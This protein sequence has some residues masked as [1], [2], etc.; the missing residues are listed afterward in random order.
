MRPARL[1]LIS[2]LALPTVAFAQS[3]PSSVEE[4]A[5]IQY[6]IDKSKEDIAKQ[7]GNKPVD[8][9]SREERL[10]RAHAE[11]DAA[12]QVL[13]KHGTDA[14]S[15]NHDGAKMTQETHEEVARKEEELKKKD[16]EAKQKKPEE[17]PVTVEHGL[18]LEDGFEATSGVEIEQGSGTKGGKSRSATP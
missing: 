13:D 12:Q 2:V 7:Y 16:E 1:F 18:P 14:K 15:F 17:Q 5:K 3:E 6:E 4:H 11:S 8:Q 9:L 10:E